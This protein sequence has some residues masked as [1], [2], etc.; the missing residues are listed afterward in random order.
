VRLAVQIETPIK[1]NTVQSGLAISP[2]LSVRPKA[3]F[4][5]A[6]SGFIAVTLLALTVT[7]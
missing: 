6:S 5:L 4:R 2:D 3:A 1:T 7:T